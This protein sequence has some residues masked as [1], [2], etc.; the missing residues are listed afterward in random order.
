VNYE[1][2]NGK[3]QVTTELHFDPELEK[4]VPPVTEAA[5]RDFDWSRPVKPIDIY[6]RDGK[7][8]ILDG[9]K[10]YLACLKYQQDFGYITHDFHSRI[11]AK[12][13]FKERHGV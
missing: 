11:T 12:R 5:I 9:R 7:L 3:I 8:W 2:T 10:R 6:R 1:F 13:F 4:L